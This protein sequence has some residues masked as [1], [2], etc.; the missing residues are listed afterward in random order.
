[1]LATGECA[2]GAKNRTKR[3]PHTASV[4]TKYL[5]VLPKTVSRNVIRNTASCVCSGWDLFPHFLLCWILPVAYL[6]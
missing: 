6:C 1:M 4:N 3:S 5:S 2:K